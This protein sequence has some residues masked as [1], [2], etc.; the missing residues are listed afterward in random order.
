MHM[1]AFR[2][3]W[4]ARRLYHDEGIDEFWIVDLDARTFGGSMPIDSRVDV[5]DAT[6]E[7]QPAGASTPLVLDVGAYFDQVLDAQP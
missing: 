2:R 4:T 7:W 5:L 1:Q 6:L 3:E